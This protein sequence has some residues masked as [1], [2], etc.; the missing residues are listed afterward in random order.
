MQLSPVEAWSFGAIAASAIAFVSLE[1]IAPYS[2]GQ[3]LVRP[4]F[5]VDFALGYQ[6]FPGAYPAQV[7]RAF[8]RGPFSPEP[9]R[10]VARTE[11]A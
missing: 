5:W 1:R 10:G 8:G 11:A 4:G 7:L 3:S 6:G 2:R 9:D